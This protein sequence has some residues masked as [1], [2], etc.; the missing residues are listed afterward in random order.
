MNFNRKHLKELNRNLRTKKRDFS[1]DAKR[2]ATLC[3]VSLTPS[4][5]INFQPICTRPINPISNR[6]TW[7]EELA[8][9][10]ING[11]RVRLNEIIENFLHVPKYESPK[12]KTMELYTRPFDDGETRLRISYVDRVR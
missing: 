3:R 11:M 5:S 1:T 6:K 2:I 10:L 7:E 12:P 8:E 4:K 9:I